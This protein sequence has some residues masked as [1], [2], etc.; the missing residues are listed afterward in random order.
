MSTT[1]VNETH[2]NLGK[3]PNV[4]YMCAVEVMVQSECSAN[5]YL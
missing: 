3:G 1:Q 4:Y 5:C 2:S